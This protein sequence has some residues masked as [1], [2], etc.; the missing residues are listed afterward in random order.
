MAYST[1]EDIFDAI[2]LETVRRLTD[3]DSVGIVDTERLSRTRDD[4]HEVVK[5]Y[6]RGRYDLPLSDPPAILAQIE[7]AL[8]A[9]RL[10]RR[11]PNVE[12]PDSVEDAVGEAMDMLRELAK[13]ITTLGI[14]EDADDKEDAAAS[15]RSRTSSTRETLIQKMQRS[16]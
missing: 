16:Y 8:L 3:D 12:T 11:R 15:Y 6:L 14:D 5:N 7:V 4:A 1:D 9:E 2:G 10:Y 13:G